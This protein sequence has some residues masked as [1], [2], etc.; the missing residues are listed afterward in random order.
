M[1]SEG[2]TLVRD[3]S[4]SEPVALLKTD[5]SRLKWISWYVIVQCI[6]VFAGAA[7]VLHCVWKPDDGIYELEILARIM[8][9]YDTN[10]CGKTR[11]LRQFQDLQL[12]NETFGLN[13]IPIT[14]KHVSLNV[15]TKLSG[16]TRT[17]VK[18]SLGLHV[19]WFVSAI[20]LHM[21]ISIK[22][23]KV[24]KVILMIFR[25]ITMSA[26]IFD[27]CMAIVY[28]ADIQQSLTKAMII[29]YSGWG[30]TPRQINNPDDFGGWVPIMAATAW[31]RGG[32]FFLNLYLVRFVKQV[33]QKIRGKEV[34]SRI[35]K[36]CNVPFPDADYNQ[37]TNGKSLHYRAGEY[38][39]KF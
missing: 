16:Q 25:F 2:V 5:K 29:R 36:L 28:I 13:I 32:I 22:N 38:Y 12:S 14:N 4:P 34:K 21:L 6:I 26:V 15:V 19:F 3:K 20:L 39:N 31:L 33:M 17:Y 9:L 37:E 1:E 24:M 7:T 27:V 10:A 11:S 8:Y 35:S 30:M 23:M 18:F